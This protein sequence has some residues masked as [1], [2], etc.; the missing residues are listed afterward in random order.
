MDQARDQQQGFRASTGIPRLSRLPTWTTGQSTLSRAYRPTTSSLARSGS[1]VKTSSAAQ[2]GNAQPKTALEDNESFPDDNDIPEQPTISKG[3][4]EPPAFG[5]S[6]AIPYSTPKTKRG[7]RPSLSDRTIETLSRIPPSPS[8]ARRKSG[9]HNT[10]SPMRLP[11][12]P[13]SSMS[14]SRSGVHTS[15]PTSPSKQPSMPPVPSVTLK[16][17]ESSRFSTSG[18]PKV[19]STRTDTSKSRSDNMHINPRSASPAKGTSATLRVRS[20]RD[21]NSKYGGGKTSGSKTIVTRS[22]KKT[23]SLAAAFEPPSAAEASS[24]ITVGGPLKVKTGLRAPSKREISGQSDST[25]AS[26]LPAYSNTSSMSPRSP[27][28]PPTSVDSEPIT[29]F[30]KSSNSSRTLRDT[31]AKAKAQAAKTRQIGSQKEASQDAINLDEEDPFS[32][33]PNLGGSKGLLRKRIQGGRTSGVL[34]ISGMDFPQI[35]DDVLKMYE[36][37]PTAA[38]SAW[39]E[40]VD[41]VKFIGADN[42]FEQLRDDAFPDTPVGDFEDEQNFQFRGLEVLDLHGNILQGLPLG[43]RRLERL[44]TLN[45][46][47][48][49]LDMSSLDIICNLITLKELYLSNNSLKG[50]LDTTITRVHDLQVLDL[51]DNNLTDLPNL[52]SLNNLKI[53]NVASNKLTSLPLEDLSCLPLIELTVHHNLLSGPLSLL[54]STSIPTLQTLDLSSNALISITSSSTTSTPT[55]PSLTT[56][57]LSLNRLCSLPPLP[58]LSP[59]LLTLNVPENALSDLPS[60]FTQLG[61]LKSANLRD[62]DIKVLDAGIAGMESLMGLD[63]AGNPLRERKLLAVAGDALAIKREL[64]KKLEMMGEEDGGVGEKG[65]EGD[66]EGSENGGLGDG[67][68]PAAAP[69]ATAPSA[70]KFTTNRARKPRKEDQAPSW[71]GG[72][73]E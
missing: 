68:G 6:S 27:L 37:D 25:T 49:K 32:Q 22:P 4:V 18:A 14:F 50:P 51:K 19:L 52:H 1:P 2:S 57:S 17:R 41:L 12:R 71:L 23:P 54:P 45:L 5:T 67:G 36:F 21:A 58:S 3:D 10:D 39:A 62:N 16:S 11:S 15:R 9:F 33:V 13:A 34:N 40:S 59:N 72:W 70:N 73:D 31:I 43:L 53:L 56:L 29:S 7:P 35:P 42:R 69:A 20:E 24:T 46:S 65:E 44:H 55:F 30:R 48:N 38:G 63:V 47:G 8:P 66:G 26:T 64:A 28:S 61:K 60:G